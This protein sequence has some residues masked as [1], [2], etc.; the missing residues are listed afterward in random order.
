MAA[1]PPRPIAHALKRARVNPMRLVLAGVLGITLSVLGTGSAFASSPTGS[2]STSGPLLAAPPP[3]DPPTSTVENACKPPTTHEDNSPAC[4]HGVL[5]AIN[6]A[7]AREGVVPMIL[8]ANYATLT[9]A[10][11]MFVV[12]SQERTGRGLPAPVG[13]VSSLDTVAMTAAKSDTDPMGSGAYN[14]RVAW[15]GGPYS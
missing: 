15:F 5:S 10:E 4:I 14:T 6:K 7:R 1:Q 8:P 9:P 3:G 11:Q 12:I 2:A 13:L